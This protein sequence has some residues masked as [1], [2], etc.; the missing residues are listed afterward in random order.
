MFFNKR[1]R[2]NIKIEQI[3]SL[4]NSGYSIKDSA[5]I[6]GCTTGLIHY[7]LQKL[8][9][10]LPDIHPTALSLHDY[11]ENH[12]VVSVRVVSCEPTPVY[13]IT[14]DDH[15]NFALSA[16][17]F[18]HNSKD[19]S[20]SAACSI[21][22]C[23][24][25][26]TGLLIPSEDMQ[27]ATEGVR[28]VNSVIEIGD[29]ELPLCKI[30]EDYQ[31]LWTFPDKMAPLHNRSAYLDSVNDD[32]LL[33]IGYKQVATFIV[34]FVDVFE[35]TDP[36][37]VPVVLANIRGMKCQFV[38]TAPTAPWPIV[39]SIRRAN[40][41][42]VSAD[43][44]VS[45]KARQRHVR[46][47]RTITFQHLEVMVQAIKS[48]T[49]KFCNDNRLVREL[50]EITENNYDSKPFAMAL[51]GWLHYNQQEQRG[52]TQTPMPPSVLTSGFAPRPASPVGQN[53]P[54]S[55]KKLPRSVISRR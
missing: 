31:F 53:H 47:L 36:E 19:I 54:S 28:D 35:A 52:L 39:E 40:I 38:A 33:V 51:A 43:A 27:R 7:R 10:G 25:N 20:D 37:M 55:E 26:M 23:T 24:L 16:G 41:R 5:C 29:K 18:V 14:V 30:T 12:K 2:K 13:D 1:T 21:Y 48:G 32:V 17:V 4:L 34:D 6:L 3:L 8:K 9:A 50:Y 49:L 11:K 22:N 15:H 45:E 46:P 44:A 42:H